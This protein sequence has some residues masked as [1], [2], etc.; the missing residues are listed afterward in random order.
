MDVIK[1]LFFHLKWENTI[2]FIAKKSLFHYHIEE[3]E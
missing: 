1:Q 2:T 3:I